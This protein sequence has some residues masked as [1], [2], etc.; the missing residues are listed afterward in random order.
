MET[1]AILVAVISLLGIMINAGQNAWAAEQQRK[2]AIAADQRQLQNQKE[3]LDYQIEKQGETNTIATQKGH[4]ADAGFNPALLYGNMTAPGLIDTGSG[5]AQGTMPDMKMLSQ[6]LPISD[7]ASNYLQ[8]RQQKIL[9]QQVNSQEH[10]NNS[11]FVRNM[12]I[13]AENM[14]NTRFQKTL[15]KNIYDKSMLELDMMKAQKEGI[16]IANNRASLMLPLELENQGLINEQT[17]T[18]IRETNERIKNYPVERAKLRADMKYIN[19][20]I[21]RN[22][23]LNKLT[24]A[25]VKEVQ[26]NYRGTVVERIMQEYGL[27]NRSLPAH[28][29]KDEIANYYL[30]QPQLMGAVAQLTS[31]GFSQDEAVQTVL[32][33]TASNAKD[34]SPSLVNAVSRG[35]SALILKK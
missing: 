15:E 20:Q 34:V 11:E 4:A 23:R 33:Y 2:E 27:A 18:Q 9:Q 8:V 17:A 30:R 22:S 12:S 10:V 31:L 14:R 16:D 1:A 26:E 28:L 21:E 24:D 6:R 5:S 3:L 19:S 29:R 13:A 7:I 35:I 32:W 25:Q